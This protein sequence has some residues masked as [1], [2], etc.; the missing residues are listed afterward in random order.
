MSTLVVGI[1]FFSIIGYGGYKYV[2]DIK[3]NTCPGCSPD[4]T[5]SRCKN[6]IV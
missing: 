2:K 6:K 4:C 3:N 1:I 5:V